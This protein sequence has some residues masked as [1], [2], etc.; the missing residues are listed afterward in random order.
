MREVGKA[1]L[2]WDSDRLMT[3]WMAAFCVAGVL[4]II[5]RVR[6]IME[7]VEKLEHVLTTDHTE[8][9]RFGFE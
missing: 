8:I 7:D 4:E 2:T 1:L 6:I 9:Q 5:H 3:L